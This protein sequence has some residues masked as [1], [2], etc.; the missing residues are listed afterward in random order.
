MSPF[1]RPR[2][3]LHRLW[4]PINDLARNDR[5]SIPTTPHQELRS[6]PTTHRSNFFAPR[7]PHVRTTPREGVLQIMVQRARSSC[8]LA[9]AAAAA[10]AAATATSGACSGGNGIGNGN[11]NGAGITSP[12]TSEASTT[13]HASRSSVVGPPGSSRAGVDPLE[14]TLSGSSWVNCS[15]S[16]GDTPT[17]DLVVRPGP[18]PIPPAPPPC[19]SCF[20]NAFKSPPPTPEHASRS[21]DQRFYSDGGKQDGL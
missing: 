2:G 19:F 15:A 9:V 4:A 20:D 10:A 18:S 14:K 5:R 11:G 6:T 17:A 12:R 1:P 3:A 13:S 7:S 8:S 21:A 16:S